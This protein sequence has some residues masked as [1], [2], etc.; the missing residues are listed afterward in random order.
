MY[1]MPMGDAPTKKDYNALLERI[2]VLESKIL[3]L[4]LKTDQ[5]K[6][7]RTRKEDNANG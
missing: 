3:E 6:R 1:L 2:V 5:S 4:E 7:T